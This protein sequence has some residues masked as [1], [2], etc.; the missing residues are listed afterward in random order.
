MR[1]ARVRRAR[2]AATEPKDFKT[3]GQ[4][5]SHFFPLERSQQDRSRGTARERGGKAADELLDRLGRSLRF[6]VPIAAG[7]N[8]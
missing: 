6:D 7:P 2:R 3:I 5:A 4:V 1:K 8:S